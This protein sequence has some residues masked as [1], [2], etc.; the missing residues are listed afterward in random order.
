MEPRFLLILCTWR[1]L[2]EHLCNIQKSI[3]LRYLSKIVYLSKY[4]IVIFDCHNSDKELSC[5]LGAINLLLCVVVSLVISISWSN[6]QDNKQ[7]LS[8]I[9]SSY[10]S[11]WLNNKGLTYT[12]FTQQVNIDTNRCISATWLD[13]PQTSG[14]L[15][16]HTEKTLVWAWHVKSLFAGHL[17]LHAWIWVLQYQVTGLVVLF[18]LSIECM[19]NHFLPDLVRFQA[20]DL[21]ILPVILIVTFFKYRYWSTTTRKGR[22][23]NNITSY[24][25]CTRYAKCM[26]KYKIDKKYPS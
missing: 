11:S 23:Y 19:V 21:P 14:V 7:S 10:Q 20:W 4:A 17:R 1:F 18:V 6:W 9:S 25:K 13:C 24:T 16:L 8:E 3:P 26:K 22:V 15:W 2:A 5:W 12:H